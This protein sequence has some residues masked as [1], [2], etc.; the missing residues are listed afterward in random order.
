MQVQGAPNASIAEVP[1]RR[2]I[3]DRANP[4]YPHCKT[5]GD[6]NGD[7]QVDA[8]VASAGGEG[9]YWYAWPNW[10]KHRIA[11]GDFSTDM[12]T[13]DVDGDGDL[14]VIFPIENKLLYWFENPRPS[15]DPAMQQWRR[16]E[17]D[18]HGGHDVEVND[19]DRD[20]KLDIVVRNGET[21]IFLQRSG[22]SKTA[23]GVA[24]HKVTIPTGGRGGTGLGD[25]DGDGDLDIAQNG[26]WLE[27][28]SNPD[29]EWTRHEIAAGW[30]NDCAVL[31][32]DINV[33]GR[34]DVFIAPAESK[35]QIVWYSAEDSKSG[36]W[37]EHVV[38]PSTNFVHT[39]KVADVN[40]DGLQ[41]VI[42]A[43][44]EQSPKRRVSVYYNQGDALKWK[45]QI[46]GLSGSHNPRVADFGNDGDIDIFGANHGNHAGPTPID[47]WENLT[48]DHSQP[49]ALDRW[50]RHVIDSKRPWRALFIAV[51]ILTMTG[52]M[53]L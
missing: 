40:N 21:R 2:I 50:K 37:V 10:S 38:E 29:D 30:L 45:K 15:G 5:I 47:L 27:T 9:L 35:G 22:D 19:L 49:L 39:F 14:D 6:I 25:L 3:I 4:H 41:D 28:P 48:V 51:P 7:G 18:N 43:E 31:I 17:I 13:G 12:Q 46:V 44:M 32:H 34:P 16:H 36:P 52:I 53:T 24:W 42:A 33:D 11:V 8:L 26:Y 1:F 20:G 23:S